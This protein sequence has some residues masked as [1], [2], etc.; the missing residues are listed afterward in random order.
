MH[1]LRMSVDGRTVD[2]GTLSQAP[3]TIT[4]KKLKPT[5]MPPLTL[6]LNNTTTKLCPTNP[7][8]V[9]KEQL[10]L[11]T[12]GSTNKRPPNTMSTLS[13][14]RPMSQLKSQT[15]NH[16]TTNIPHTNQFLRRPTPTLVDGRTVDG[17]TLSQAPHTTTTKRLFPT[18]QLP[19]KL[20][21]TSTT[22]KLALTSP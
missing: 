16:T 15:S 2:G 13:P 6:K 18:S 1:Q 7:S 12:N 4:A 21:L 3:P 20:R 17:G 10:L 14:L 11:T 9:D 8:L 5:S 19:Q 22:T